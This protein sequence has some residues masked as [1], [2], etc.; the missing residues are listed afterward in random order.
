MYVYTGAYLV[1]ITD[2]GFENLKNVKKKNV[3]FAH[4]NKLEQIYVKWN[5]KSQILA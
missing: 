3:F 2:Q 1:E 5:T 4:S